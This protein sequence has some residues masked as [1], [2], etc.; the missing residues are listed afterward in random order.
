MHFCCPSEHL[1][2]FI[3]IIINIIKMMLIVEYWLIDWSAD[4]SQEDSGNYSCEVRGPQ[5]ALLGHVTHYVFVRG[6]H[7]EHN[8]YTSFMKS[9]VNDNYIQYIQP[10]N[11]CCWLLLKII[12]F[13]LL[14]GLALF[15]RV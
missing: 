4:V 8:W 10:V 15:L 2:G 12:G 3:I 9:R 11:Y 14:P 13:K 7:T 5:S 6:E 1:I